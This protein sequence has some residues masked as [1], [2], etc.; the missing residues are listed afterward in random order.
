[1]MSD[2]PVGAFLSGGVDSSTNVALMSRVSTTP[3]N[4]FS[5][6]YE[7]SAAYNEFSWARQ[8]ADRFHTAH[9]ELVIGARDFWQAVPG[10]IHHLD[11]PVGGRS[12]SPCTYC[13]AGP[14]RW[15]E[16]DSS[17]EGGDEIF[18][19]YDQYLRIEA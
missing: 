11:E 10:V 19:G 15:G 2:V 4:T 18:A 5:I 1:M 6:G 3:V 14:R 9:R 12:T 16:G 7:G 8:I 17:W 13:A